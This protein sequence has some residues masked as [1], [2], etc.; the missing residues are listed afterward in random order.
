MTLDRCEVAVVGGGIVGAAVA[1]ELAAR[2]REVLILEKE[3]R[4][5]AHQSG[6]NSGEIHSGIYYAPGSLKAKLCV[7]GAE[8]MK[9]FCRER[10]LPIQPCGK[11]IV[12]TREEER[13]RLDELY[14]RGIANGVP[15][16]EAIGPERL[17]EIEPHAQG[18][19]ALWVPGV[20]ITDFAAVASELAKSASR[21][22]TG[23]RVV[24]IRGTTLE[25][26][27]GTIEAKSIVA[28]A[29]LQS[30]RLA[31]TGLRIIPFRGEYATLRRPELVRG[32]IYPVPDPA[33]PFLGI[34]FTRRLDGTVEAGPNAVLAF[35]REGYRWRDI[36]PGDLLRAVGF[37]G[38]W[39]MA[40]HHWKAGLGEVH[41]SISRRRLL[42]DMRR[43]VP[44]TVGSDLLPGRSGVRA[45]AVEPDGR[46]VDDFRLAVRDRVIHVVN[47]PSP[48]ATASLAIAR[49]VAD[50]GNFQADRH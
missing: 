44:E 16:V 33:L 43:L 11:V 34:H 42:R 4:L 50:A 36:D 48:A 40:A 15:G 27:Q 1:A 47:A 28:C 10:G 29:G 37:A 3:R 46:L 19:A 6:H 45:Q 22:L 9:R 30:D 26:T 18:L 7:Q 12:A 31:R 39:K 17:R 49:H 2:G 41:R 20:C 32:L 23:V 13:G 24:S 5:A 21:V 25:T 14:R 35:K 38:F 8:L